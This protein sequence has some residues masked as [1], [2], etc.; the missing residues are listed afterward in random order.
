MQKI[1]V[2]R[3]Y[4]RPNCRHKYNYLTVFFDTWA[5]F[6]K[7]KHLT[8]VGCFNREEY[9]IAAKDCGSINRIIDVMKSKCYTFLAALRSGIPQKII[10][11][12]KR[13]KQIVA[14][15]LC[16]AFAG[17]SFSCIITYRPVFSGTFGYIQLR[18]VYYFN[19][20]TAI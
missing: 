4:N 10:D 20:L 12:T 6:L 17:T 18:E 3:Y 2:W 16:F 1:I 8:R 19:Q 7:E 9:S 15:I 13:I 11:F 14:I 5:V